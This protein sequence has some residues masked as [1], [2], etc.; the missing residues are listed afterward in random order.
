[1][2]R[3]GK[4]VVV[5]HRRNHPQ[6]A[7]ATEPSLPQEIIVEILSRLPVKSLCRFRCVSKSWLSL[8]SSPQ[9]AKTHLSL[10]LKNKSFQSQR[11]RLIFSS[12]NLYSA[13]YESIGND[14]YDADGESSVVAFEI[15]Y[16]LKDKSNGWCRLL[17]YGQDNLGWFKMSE[18]EDDNPVT[19]K[20]DAPSSVNPR[21]WVEFWG[22]CNGLVCIAPDEDTLFLFN[23][24]TGESKK[25]PD[26]PLSGAAGL[27][28]HGFGY[29]SVSDDYK[30]VRIDGRTN[31]SV[32][33]L[34]TDSWRR[35]GVFPYGD[36]VYDSGTLLNGAVHWAVKSG[37][38]ENA[39]YSISA[40]DLEKELFQ[41]LPAP[42]VGDTDSEFVVGALGK[43]LCMIHS[44]NYMHDDFWVM[45]KYGMGESWTRISISLSY[46]CMAPLCL[47]KN[48]GALLVIDGRL[49][50]YNL[51]KDTYKFLIVHGIP[52]GVGFEADTYIESLISPS[53]LMQK[54]DP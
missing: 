3:D 30:V 23:P 6:Q 21:N 50:L 52:G 22:S 54:F 32:Y 19:V 1:M 46:I 45:R 15:D 12:N 29:D 37:E 2:D 27:G 44:R 11:L 40:F 9:F 16:P 33:S 38:G 47:T 7:E 14:D 51:E 28:A 25:I 35:M 20:V 42:D 43:C 24:T 48:G 10:A 5:K 17:G 13:E 18:D 36:Y 26:E 49:V 39:K 53:S 34:R 41:E 31:V 4:L 8:I